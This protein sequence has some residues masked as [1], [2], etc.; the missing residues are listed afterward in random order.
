MENFIPEDE[1]PTIPPETAKPIKKKRKFSFLRVFFLFIFLIA[2]AATSFVLFYKPFVDSTVPFDKNTSNDN[3]DPN[4][5][6]SS[7]KDELKGEIYNFLILGLDEESYLTD[8]IMVVSFN[9]TE[10]SVNIVQIPRDTYIDGHTANYAY[11]RFWLAN[12]YDKSAGLSGAVDLL[13]KNLCIKIHYYALME[14]EGF[15]NIVDAIGGV[16]M[17]VPHDL[18]YRDDAQNLLIN[19]KK[20]QQTLNG[21]K[22]EQFVRYRAG[23]AMADIARTNAQKLFMSAF[24]KQLK[25]NFNIGTVKALTEQIIKYVYTD[26]SPLDAAYFA[27]ETLSVDPEKIRMATMPG[28]GS[29]FIKRKA[30]M[31]LVN[32]YLNIYNFEITDDIFD[33]DRVFS[34]DGYLHFY[35]SNDDMSE[36]YTADDPS[37][38]TPDL[39]Y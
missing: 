10:H 16:D 37:A 17:Y 35:N 24:F 12:N 20:G 27:K 2:L 28:G 15:R 34:K 13:Q 21:Y 32:E 23:Y 25:N 26:I 30:T 22:A 33:K 7:G 1:Q 3:A 4:N 39:Y 11:K 38:A 9:V 8:V 31:Q 29:Y 36:G 6:G 14:L 5:Q 19:L 18:Y